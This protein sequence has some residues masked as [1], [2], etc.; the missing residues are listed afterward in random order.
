MQRSNV[1]LASALLHERV[2]NNSGDDLGHIE[3]VVIDSA[4]GYIKYAITSMDNRLRAIPWR[5]FDISPRADFVL[6]N[7]DRHTLDQAPSFD[8]EHWPDMTDSAWES[9][10][11][12]H[13]G[14]PAGPAPV[15]QERT[16]YVE[17]RPTVRR[18]EISALA[19]LALVFFLMG[20][21]WVTYLVATR[22]WDQAREDLKSSFQSAA[23]AMRETTQDA[24]LTAK[25]KTALSLSKR[26]PVNQIN[27]DSQLDVVTLRGEVPS[28]ETSTL[29]E[30]I[31]RDTPGVREVHNFLFV[32]DRPP[33]TGSRE[34]R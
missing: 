32:I 5:A 28:Q 22:G 21:L 31:A 26:I 29:A 8:R 10:T 11:T 16:V 7:V 9:R 2:R 27:V 24:T 23:Y 13:Y 4:T 30:S 25:V 19:G 33:V 14:Y 1:W 12:K 34:I 6:L 18:K 17:R 15:I 3:D 20:L